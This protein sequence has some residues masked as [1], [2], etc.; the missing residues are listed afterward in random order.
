MLIQVDDSLLHQLATARNVSPSDYQSML[1]GLLQEFLA[2]EADIL[3]AEKR[4]ADTT[5]PTFT[6]TEVA[7]TLGLEHLL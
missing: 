1:E 2:E 7:Q 4:V 3:E 5:E 6:L